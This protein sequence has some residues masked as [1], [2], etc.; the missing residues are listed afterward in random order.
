M[1]GS[2][3]AELKLVIAGNHD[4]ELDQRYWDENIAKLD[5]ED[6][7][8]DP[9]YHAKAIEIMTG[10]L[11]RQAGVTYLIEGTHE[12]KLAN[13]A[14]FK[15]YVS[16]YTP[17]YGD[18]AFAYARSEDRFNAPADVEKKGSKSI[19]INPIPEDADIVMTHGP[20][21]GILDLCANGNVGCGNLLAAIRRVKPMVHCFGH[22]HEGS[23]VEVVDWKV[24]EQK[25]EEKEAER[26]GGVERKNE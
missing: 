3:P 16:P 6:D 24:F 4:L 1:L 17:A 11:A 9:E 19:A 22:V 21:K 10:E 12:F 18:W 20:P 5:A 13:G 15:I 8:D 7:G 26:I 14:T 2:I 23:G 25:E